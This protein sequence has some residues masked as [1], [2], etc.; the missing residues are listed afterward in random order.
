MRKRTKPILFFLFC[1][2]AIFGMGIHVLVLAKWVR[3]F[4]GS[5]FYVLFC[6]WCTYCYYPDIWNYNKEIFFRS[7]KFIFSLVLWEIPVKAQSSWRM[8]QPSLIRIVK[9]PF[10]YTLAKV[11]MHLF[12]SQ[13]FW[14]AGEGGSSAKIQPLV[15]LHP[16]LYLARKSGTLPK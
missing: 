9:G 14:V 6:T 5:T 1:Q 2:G 3:N 16:I 12:D 15:L 10:K 11:G 13:K 4:I 7:W 8:Q